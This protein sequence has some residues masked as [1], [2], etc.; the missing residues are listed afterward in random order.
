MR[1]RGNGS[2]AKFKAR[3]KQKKLWAKYICPECK[4]EGY[5]PCY[6]DGPGERVRGRPKEDYCP[7]GARTEYVGFVSKEN[8]RET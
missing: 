2:V 1:K 7:C 3:F 4:R 8:G 5:Y 6:L